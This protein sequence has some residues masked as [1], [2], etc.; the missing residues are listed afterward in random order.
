MA[1]TAD[2]MVRVTS[3]EANHKSSLT[4]QRGIPLDMPGKDAAKY[5]SN[6]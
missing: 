1:T 6:F 5:M 2:L 3:Q 4:T